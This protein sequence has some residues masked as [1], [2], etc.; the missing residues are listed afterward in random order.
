[1]IIQASR[2]QDGSRKVTHISQV[3]PLSPEG[4]YRVQDI[5][6]FE[7]T[8]MEKDRIVGEHK[9]AGNLPSFLEEI[10]LGGF[11]IPP[12]LAELASRPGAREAIEHKATEH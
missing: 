5:Y 2:L 9:A 10:E 8:G 4:R 7:R 3:L 6:R 12:S 11:A 1:V